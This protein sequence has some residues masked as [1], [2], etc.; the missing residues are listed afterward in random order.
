MYK[1]TIKPTFPVLNVSNDTNYKKI[2]IEENKQ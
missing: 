1:L 2:L